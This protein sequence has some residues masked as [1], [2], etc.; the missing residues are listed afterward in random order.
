MFSPEQSLPP[1]LGLGWVHERCWVITPSLEQAV[2]FCQ[3]LHPPSTIANSQ[4][5]HT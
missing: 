4:L 3:L 5:L 2:T 1:Q